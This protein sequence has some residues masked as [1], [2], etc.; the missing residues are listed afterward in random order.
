[1]R[2]LFKMIEAKLKSWLVLELVG[3]SDAEKNFWY[4]NHA[5]EDDTYLRVFFAEEFENQLASI[6]LTK[7]SYPQFDSYS[8]RKNP[9]MH[10]PHSLKSL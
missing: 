10:L 7:P 6:F 5:G 2:T 1:M 9:C 8:R 3:R 4:S